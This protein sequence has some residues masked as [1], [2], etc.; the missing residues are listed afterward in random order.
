MQGLNL[1]HY[2]KE[3]IMRGFERYY[4]VTGESGHSEKDLPSRLP[5][6]TNI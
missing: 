1:G 2:C 5:Q 6:A 4:T 3:N